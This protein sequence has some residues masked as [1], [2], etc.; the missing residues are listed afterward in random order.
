MPASDL[1]RRVRCDSGAIRVG[2]MRCCAHT[3]IDPL[4]SLS[5]S[6]T[7][8]RIHAFKRCIGHSRTPP[9]PSTPHTHGQASQ[10][11]SGGSSQEQRSRRCLSRLGSQIRPC[12]HSSIPARSHAVRRGGSTGDRRGNQSGQT[13]RPATLRHSAA[14][15]QAELSVSGCVA[16][17]TST[18]P[19]L[20]LCH[21]AVIAAV[22][23]DFF[24]LHLPSGTCCAR[25]GRLAA[26]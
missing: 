7:H 12:G 13:H 4:E 25:C 17:H 18:L 15:S 6:L 8:S 14:E 19:C 20:R 1:T 2:A 21:P 5:D 16:A 26:A 11:R 23:L 22:A 24:F 9:A 10:R 3:A